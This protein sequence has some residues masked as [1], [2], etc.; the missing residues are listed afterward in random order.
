[1]ERRG[2]G[3]QDADIRIR[4]PEMFDDGLEVGANDA[5]WN[6]LFDVI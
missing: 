3:Q 2:L 5:Q 6:P 1:M 4:G